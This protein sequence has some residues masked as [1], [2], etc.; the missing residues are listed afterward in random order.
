MCIRDRKH[1]L[2]MAAFTGYVTN[3]GHIINA[4]VGALICLVVGVLTFTILTMLDARMG[5]EIRGIHHQRNEAGA[6]AGHPIFGFVPA[7]LPSM[8]FLL[9]PVFV[10]I[11]YGIGLKVGP[12]GSA[13]GIK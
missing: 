3:Q 2:H 7:I 6:G 10:I 9:V 4:K 13:A 5:K 12:Q 11:V 8:G 1:L